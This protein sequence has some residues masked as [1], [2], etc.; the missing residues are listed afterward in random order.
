MRVDAV[1]DYWYERCP[2][3]NCSKKEIETGIIDGVVERILLK[4]APKEGV[5][6]AIS[7]I[8][9]KGV[10][11][12]LASSSSY[13][14]IRTVLDKFDLKDKFELVHSA[15]DEEYGKPHPAVYLTTARKLQVRPEEC[16]AIEDSFNGVLAA[17]DA[18][19]RCIAVPDSFSHDDARFD[20]ADTRLTSLS[21]IN[22]EV[23]SRLDSKL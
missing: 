12:A 5:A 16:L 13:R 1:V 4:A 14:I 10:R 21:E 9:S 8:Q 17:K 2:W 6:S 22:E 7:F 19:M 15:E 11:I 3:E 23:W 20:L 18:G